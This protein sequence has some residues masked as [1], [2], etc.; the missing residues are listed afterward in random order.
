MDDTNVTGVHKECTMASFII[1]Q[2]VVE[3]FPV[4]VVKVVDHEVHVD[5]PVLLW[6]I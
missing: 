1:L 3:H 6:T 2:K 4:S 5:L